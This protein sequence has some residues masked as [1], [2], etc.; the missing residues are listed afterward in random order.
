VVLA[1]LDIRCNQ[2]Y[3]WNGVKCGGNILPQEGADNSECGIWVVGGVKA[4]GSEQYAISAEGDVETNRI[5]AR[6]ASL[7]VGGNL[8]LHAQG[9]KDHS[10]IKEVQVGPAAP[11]ED[12]PP[13]RKPVEGMSEEELRKEARRILSFRP[14]RKRR[15]DPDNPVGTILKEGNGILYVGK[16]EYGKLAITGEEGFSYVARFPK[17]AFFD[18][19]R[20]DGLFE[21]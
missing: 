3:A 19:S 14:L 13:P 18:E 12:E 4:G 21:T 16:M 10:Y 15:E 1:A 2:L 6:R 7:T 5:C 9:E 17:D 20:W 8:I 11:K